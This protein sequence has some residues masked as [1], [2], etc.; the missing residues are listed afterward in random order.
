MRIQIR[1]LQA[2]KRGAGAFAPM[3][4][5]GGTSA[6]NGQNIVTGAP[7]T[8]NVFAPRPAALDD[9]SLGGPFNQSSSVSPNFIRPSIYVAHENRSLRFPGQVKVD[10]VLPVPAIK[11][12][13][14]Q[15]QVQHRARLGGRTVTQ[16][17]RP[18]T[19]WPTYGKKS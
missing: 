4:T 15:L 5:M 18:F 14:V 10:N 13:K 2:P 1:T 12:G 8:V 17:V 3:L 6:F 9:S 11:L 19:Q 7:G 16:S